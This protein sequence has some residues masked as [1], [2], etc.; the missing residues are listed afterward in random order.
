MKWTWRNTTQVVFEENA[1]NNNLHKYVVRGSRVLCTFGGGSIERNGCREEVER[2]LRALDCEILWE[3]GIPA[4]PEYDRL[5]EIITVA[6]EFKPDL[7]LAVGGGSV[8]DGTKFISCGI[9]LSKEIDPWKIITEHAEPTSYVPIGVVLTIP[10]TGSEW[11]SGF[12]ISRRSISAKLAGLGFPVYPRFSLLDVRY[13]MTLPVK[14]I[15]NGVFDAI[16]HCMDEYLTPQE[17]PLQ[18]LLI[19]SVFKELVRIGP[20]VI[21]ENS[22]KELHERL[23]MAASFALNDIMTLGVECDW[24]IHMI[25]QQLTALYGIDHGATLSICSIPFLES[26]FDNRKEKY[27]ISA[28]YVFG[29]KEGS[30]EDKARSFLRELRQFIENIGMPTKVSEVEGVNIEE[31]DINKCTDMVWSSAGNSSFGY[32]GMTTKEIT[33]QVLK[34]VIQ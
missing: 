32:R 17:N 25:G 12:V 4:N 1:V 18:D 28:E 10:A 33:R 19:M 24:S 13:T 23:I 7:L 27:A 34:A 5:I 20:E 11:N 26:Q 21:K 22:S 16:T 3:G 8:I 6:R 15:R 31:G 30:I 2:S 14:Q 9:N 29:I